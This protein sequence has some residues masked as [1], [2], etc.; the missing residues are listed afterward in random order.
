[1]KRVLRHI[2]FVATALSCL[3]AV[4]DESIEKDTVFFYDTWE[5]IFSVEPDTMIV[6]LAIDTS[7]P[8]ELYFETSDKAVNKRIKKDYV[9]AALG[10]TTWLI[11]SNYLKQYFKGDSKRL[12]GYVPLFFNEKVAYAVAEEYSFA[13]L[14][15]IAFNVISTYNYYIDFKRH[16][17]IRVDEK[18]LSAIL[19]DYNDLMMRYESMKDSW[20]QRIVNDYFLQ[21]VDRVTDDPMRA[22]ILDFLEGK[23]W[24]NDNN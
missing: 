2:I 21:Y 5:R 18:T 9:A 3:H 10:D 24:K 6:D 15:D 13:E 11:N 4:A 12:H 8:F 22:D 17:V 20:L 16:K 23:E 1:M 14:G 7:S 19:T